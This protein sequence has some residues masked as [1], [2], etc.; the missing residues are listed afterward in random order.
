VFGLSGI[1]IFV[2]GFNFKEIIKDSPIAH[3]EGEIHGYFKE[4]QN[5]WLAKVKVGSTSRNK[6]EIKLRGHQWRWRSHLTFQYVGGAHFN[7]QR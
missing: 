1:Q 3:M 2:V 4:I 7:L 5:I 6:G